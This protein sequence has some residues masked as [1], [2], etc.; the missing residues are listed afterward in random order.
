MKASAFYSEKCSIY[1][2]LKSLFFNPYLIN[3][4]VRKIPRRRAWQTTPGFLP[5]E[6]HGQRSLV[7]YGP[8]DSPDKS[9]SY[10]TVWTKY[11][12]MRVTVFSQV[13]Q[14]VKNP[15]AKT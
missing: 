4:W 9:L 3:P 8:W 6:S 15:P 14:V 13:K 5:K 2:Q 12:P 11:K 1:V 10:K 7:G